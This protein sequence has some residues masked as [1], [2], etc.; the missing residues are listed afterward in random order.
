MILPQ[1]Y[2]AALALMIL[3]ML[4]WGSWA[5]TFKL[6]RNWRFEL[7]YFDYAFGVAIASIIYAFTAGNMGFDGLMFVDDFMHAGKRQWLY[8]FT[9]GVVFNLANMLLVAA[10]SVAG[11]SVAFPVGI[12]MALVIGVFLNHLIKPGGNATLLFVGCAIVVAAIIVDAMAYHAL[13]RIK[14]LELIKSGK[15][16]STLVRVPLKGVI[17]SIA[18]GILMG[19][20]FPLVELSKATEVG[21]GPYSAGFVFAGGVFFSTFVFN[22]FFMNLPVQGEPVELLDYFRGRLKDHALGWLGGAIWYTGAIASFAAAS[23]PE[24]VQV[25]PAIS[26][27]VGQG[28]TMVSALWG[29][30]VWKEFAG[31]DTRAKS[32]LVMM[33]VLFLTGLSLISIAPLYPR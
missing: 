32:L 14:Q 30:L 24:Q 23:A 11:L 9:G 10:I 21:L 31:A 1:T 20:F 18:S 7:Y 27:A 25:G 8:G 2:A 12:G 4:S 15:A 17:I 26:Y 19:C 28:A 5:N 33:F 22:M 16:K 29:V 3:A 13:A 6:T